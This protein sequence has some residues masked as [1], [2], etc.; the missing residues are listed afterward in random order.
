M[1]VA[2]EGEG[3]GDSG[4]TATLSILAEGKECWEILTKVLDNFVA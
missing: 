3:G 1:S 4:W 2:G